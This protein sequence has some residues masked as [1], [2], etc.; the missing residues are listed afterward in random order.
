MCMIQLYRL[1]S[2]DSN[3]CCNKAKRNVCPRTPLSSIYEVDHARDRLCQEKLFVHTCTHTYM[4]A[5]WESK[6]HSPAPLWWVGT[7]QPG[8][9]WCSTQSSSVS[10][11]GQCSYVM[12]EVHVVVFPPASIPAEGFVV[13]SQVSPWWCCTAP[14]QQSQLSLSCHLLD[15]GPYQ[16]SS[17]SV[18]VWVVLSAMADNAHFSALG[19]GKVVMPGWERSYPPAPF[20]FRVWRRAGID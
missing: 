15:Q 1:H 7:A 6:T 16:A 20:C 3:F 11:S 10:G 19:Q 2:Q 18:L 17:H 5:E 14:F 4:C 8:E 13:I 12:P 9:T